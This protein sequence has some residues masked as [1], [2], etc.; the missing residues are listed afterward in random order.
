MGGDVTSPPLSC[1]GKVSIEEADAAWSDKQAQDD[2]HDAPDHLASDD[3]E[4][5]GNDQHR[6]D[7]PEDGVRRASFAS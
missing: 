5:P 4:D 6:G 3:R 2:Q 1:V 7:D